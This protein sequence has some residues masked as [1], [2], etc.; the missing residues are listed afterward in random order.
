MFQ[1]V[2]AVQQPH[3]D[4]VKTLFTE[5]ADSLNVNL[6]F[7]NFTHELSTLPGDYASPGGCLL[8][9][10]A[11]QKPAGCVALRKIDPE[12]CEMK[13]LYV[14]PEFRKTGSGRIL[15]EAIIKKARTIGYRKMRL[16]TLPSMINARR[17]YTSLGFRE[18]PAYR[19]NPVQ[20]TL[21][22]E[23]DLAAAPPG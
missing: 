11:D 5:Y 23:I 18:I 2:E 4:H 20:G 9:A 3:L 14:R 1:I 6:D 10:Y 16:D 21:F 8:L 19:Y 12:I 7:Q 13:R 17:L 22:M 15:A